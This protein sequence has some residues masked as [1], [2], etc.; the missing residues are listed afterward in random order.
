MYPI[1]QA[2]K[3]RPSLSLGYLLAFL[4]L[5]LGLAVNGCAAQNMPAPRAVT[6]WPV[7]LDAADGHIEVYQPQPEAMKGDTLTARAA[8]SLLRPSASPPVFGTAWFTAHVITD[9]DT[10]TATLSGLT[11]ND[12]RLPGATATEQ[13]DFASAI[14]RQL[15][16]M[17]VTF[18]LDQLMTSL[19]TAQQEHTEAAHIETS[20]PRI[21]FSTTP[22]TV[23]SVNGPPRLLSVD[24]QSGVSRVANTPFILLFD[25]TSRRYY[26]KA[27]ARWVTALDLPGPWLDTTNIPPAIGAAGE[28]LAIL[29]TQPSAPKAVELA[30]AAADAKI[31]VAT[32]PT[33]LIVTTG[34]PQFT[35]LSGGSLLYASNTASD[36]FLDQ[37]D[38]RYYLVLSGRW[39]AAA[40]FQEPWQYV[41]S[42]RLP[43][44]FAQIPADSPKADVLSFV[45][46]TTEA[47]E[48]VLDAGIPQTATIRRDAGADLT[49]AYDGEPKFQNV[50]ES[51]GVS[52]ALNTPEEVLRVNGQYYCCHQA[53]W[54]WSDT[55][56][57]P[58]TVS[59]TVPPAIYTL[60]PSCPDYNVTFV[61]VYDYYPDYVTC[62]YLPGYN[63]TFVYG[64]TIVYGTGYDYPGW[65]GTAYFPPACTWGFAAY[66]D[67]FA[68]DWGFDVGLYWGGAAWFAHPWHERWWSDHPS[69]RWGSHGWWGPGG[70][71]HSHEIGSHL[72]DA[73]AGGAFRE[74][75]R[76]AGLE[77]RMPGTDHG[78]PGW[79]NIYA[80]GGN[81]GRNVSPARIH[82]ASPA[83]VVNGP[84]DNVFAGSDGGVFRP[85]NSGWEQYRGAGSTWSGVDRVP[86]ANPKYRPAPSPTHVGGSFAR[87]Q[88]GL[89]QHLAARSRGNFRSGASHS[90]GGGGSHGGG[91]FHGGG[92]RR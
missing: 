4:W 39:Y 17:E 27:G 32:D 65:Y 77:A 82:S 64:S 46:E 51:P 56:T 73:R 86:D 19:D 22:A 74:G 29:A 5:L 12:V 83:R 1:F 15:S 76:D 66:Y 84:R 62:G 33:E 28:E 88:A 87:P 57:G 55:P 36:L 42:D 71:V 92:G 20:P 31:I 21:I 81:A 2:Q 16:T 44:E 38:H 8:A 40:G 6:Y 58:W 45:A 70:F 60:P 30:P 26:L 11:I 7:A 80:R 35:P 63:G 14:R 18:P 79:N 43:P 25:N 90:F 53:A 72:S 67:P 34:D 89:D 69:E 75:G 61:Y 13:Q 24:G 48:A 23:I 10:R 50:P 41:A 78:G 9:R 49:V 59:A 47:R 54:Y 91:G 68:C 52:Y 3:S 37:A 85:S